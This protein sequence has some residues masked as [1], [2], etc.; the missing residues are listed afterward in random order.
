VSSH[1]QD[2]LTMNPRL[3]LPTKV[4]FK[5]GSPPIIINPSFFLASP[6]LGDE[7]SFKG[8]SLSHPKILECEIN[9]NRNHVCLYWMIF[10]RELKLFYLFKSIIRKTISNFLLFLEELIWENKISKYYF[11]FIQIL[12]KHICKGNIIQN[13]IYQI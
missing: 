11:V 2:V 9:K 12:C 7:I 1:I 10:H 13:D 8:G 4:S 6:N 3:R 5:G